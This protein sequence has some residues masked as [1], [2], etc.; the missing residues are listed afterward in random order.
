[1]LSSTTYTHMN[2][3]I[4]THKHPHPHTQMHSPQCRKHGHEKHRIAQ[5]EVFAQV[6]YSTILWVPTAYVCV[7]VCVFQ[8][9]WATQRVVSYFRM[10]FH[11]YY[12]GARVCACMGASWIVWTMCL[13]RYSFAFLRRMSHTIHTS[14]YIER[15]SKRNRNTGTPS[16]CDTSE[17]CIPVFAANRKTHCASNR[18]TPT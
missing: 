17:V 8:H 3:H 10:P 7:C 11:S 18:N 14:T 1:M 2:I 5:I 13:L 9:M 15:H 4:H 12:Y 6:V 16:K